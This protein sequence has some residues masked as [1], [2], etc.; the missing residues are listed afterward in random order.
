MFLESSVASVVSDSATLWTVARQAPLSMG[1]S[2]QEYCSGVPC[3]SFSRGSS[4]PGDPTHISCVSCTAGRFFTHWATWEA[5]GCFLQHQKS[6]N[7]NRATI[8]GILAC[9]WPPQRPRSSSTDVLRLYRGFCTRKERERSEQTFK[10]SSISFSE[11][12]KWSTAGK[13]KQIS[14]LSRSSYRMVYFGESPL[15]TGDV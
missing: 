8:P 2:R 7:G 14:T 6:P 9:F 10:D 1:F 13:Q 3:P 12:R 15:R 4:W 5:L 11:R